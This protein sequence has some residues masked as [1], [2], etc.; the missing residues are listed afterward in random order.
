MLTAEKRE[1]GAARAEGSHMTA[2][3]DQA[4]APSPLPTAA[5]ARHR[6]MTYQSPSAASK[7][8]LYAGGSR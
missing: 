4:R 8:R 6:G 2:G 5:L 1:T 7:R 3:T